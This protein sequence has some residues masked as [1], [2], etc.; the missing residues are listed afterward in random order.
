MAR[1]RKGD[2]V[3]PELAPP[4]DDRRAEPDRFQDAIREADFL[5]ALVFIFGA[6]I[7]VVALTLG[8]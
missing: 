3:F 6:A 2:N 4:D 8:G 7:G 1:V 5:P